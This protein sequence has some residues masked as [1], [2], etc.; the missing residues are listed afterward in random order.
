MTALAAILAAGFA[1][2]APA[3]SSDEP[4]G[5]RTAMDGSGRSSGHAAMA[6]DEEGSEGDEAPASVSE[7]SAASQP[8]HPVD[9]GL[10]HTDVSSQVPV[11][12]ALLDGSLAGAGVDADILAA[13]DLNVSLLD[14]TDGG[15]P[16]QG[17]FSGLDIVNGVLEAK[18][19]RISDT[20]AETKHVAGRTVKRS[21]GNTVHHLPGAL[22]TL[23]GASGEAPT[24]ID[25][26]DLDLDVTAD[27]L[28]DVTATVDDI[29]TAD[30]LADLVA[31]VSAEITSEINDVVDTSIVDEVTG[32]LGL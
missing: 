28:A 12:L 27:V 31:D 9:G 25:G 7:T 17:A 4:A 21:V 2:A 32:S 11:V 5:F 24:P 20:V 13:I 22:D 19:P 6:D 1:S 14:F 10:P 29:V 30:I 23:S 3:Y 16:A 15:V 26:G 8:L 18:V